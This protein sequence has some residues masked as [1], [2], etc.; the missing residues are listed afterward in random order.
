M[1]FQSG[2]KSFKCRRYVLLNEL[3][4]VW[5]MKRYTCKISKNILSIEFLLIILFKE[6]LQQVQK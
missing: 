2:Q 1:V 6:L 3:F 5:L 4:Q